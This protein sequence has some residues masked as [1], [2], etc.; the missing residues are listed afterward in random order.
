MIGA[1]RA[2]IVP[3]ISSII[4]ALQVDAR[5]GDIRMSELRLDDGRRHA[6]PRELDG[7]RAVE[8]RRAV[9]GGILN[10][11]EVLDRDV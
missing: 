3:M 10:L 8:L 4:D 11:D 5:R 1:R 9:A 2:R 6:L 7:V